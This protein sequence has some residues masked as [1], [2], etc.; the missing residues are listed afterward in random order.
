[1]SRRSWGHTARHCRYC[2]K[3]GPRT[4]VGLGLAHK[5]CIPENVLRDMRKRERDERRSKQTVVKVLFALLI[6]QHPELMNEGAW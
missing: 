4:P 5:R 2:G 1:M 3:V 6:A